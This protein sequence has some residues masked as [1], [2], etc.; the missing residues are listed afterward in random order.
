MGNHLFDMEVILEWARTAA[1]WFVLPNVESAL[2][3]R[4]FASKAP[5][6]K[7]FGWSPSHHKFVI[8]QLTSINSF[9]GW[10]NHQL[11]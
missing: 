8:S 5:L 2:K 7:S 3:P 11:R 1:Y 9:D 4:W 10:L 6:Q